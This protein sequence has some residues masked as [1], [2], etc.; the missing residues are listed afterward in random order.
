MDEAGEIHRF[1]NSNDGNVHWNGSSKQNRG[2][3]VPKD[4]NKRFNNPN[5]HR[6]GPK[7]NYSH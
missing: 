5:G 6:K 4:V 1:G 7:A 2:I 3:V